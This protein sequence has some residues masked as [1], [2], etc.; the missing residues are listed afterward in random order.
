MALLCSIR[1][2]VIMLPLAFCGG[3]HGH[4]HG[5]GPGELGA[6]GHRVEPKEWYLGE[7]TSDVGATVNTTNVTHIAKLLEKLNFVNCTRRNN[8]SCNL[9]SIFYKICL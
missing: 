7:V 4:E 1:I 9:V 6:N 3:D 8:V 5:S 2:M